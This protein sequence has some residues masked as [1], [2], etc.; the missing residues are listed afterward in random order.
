VISCLE[1]PDCVNTVNNIVGVT[2]KNVADGK[3]LPQSFSR[4]GIGSDTASIIPFERDSIATKLFLPV[5]H[6][7]DTTRYTIVI[8]DTVYQLLF[9][10]VTQ[11]QFVSDD[12]GERY[13]LKDM[14]LIDSPFDSVVVVNATPGVN[15]DA[16]NLEIFK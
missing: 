11:P 13:V 2:F 9:K 1:E 15:R 5:D 7:R 6:F 12:C 10:Y 3:V 4:I 16:S 8:Q 14:E